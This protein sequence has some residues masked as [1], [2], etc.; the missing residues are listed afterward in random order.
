MIACISP[1]EKD[2]TET[3]N[4]L[5]YANRAKNMQRP[6]IPKHLLQFSAKKRK[7]AS[8]SIPPTPAKFAK[9]NS[10]IGT[11]I[12]TKKKFTPKF[13]N[14]ISA[15]NSSTSLKKTPQFS[16]E[17]LE[18]ISENEETLSE[19]SSIYPPKIDF[20]Q[21]PNL[22]VL[23]ASVLSPI[24]KK[25]QEQQNEFL[26]RLEQTLLKNKTKTPNKSSPRRSP[27]IQ[28]N[29]RIQ[30]NLEED[31]FDETL[32]SGPAFSV[33]RQ[34][35]RDGEDFEISKPFS[36]LKDVTNSRK[37]AHKEA[38]EKTASPNL[39]TKSMEGKENEEVSS[40]YS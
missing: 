10:T 32:I 31:L 33:S 21:N 34:K 12:S 23:D 36:A 15:V 1:T 39:C 6:P 24:M 3:L 18:N 14:T 40:F 35:M 8:L 16:N 25:L 5:R 2:L 26:A 27:R 4:T 30:K 9:M 38:V 13:N 28:Q 22:T 17:S 29:S 11:P 20:S 19:L 7:F 37:S